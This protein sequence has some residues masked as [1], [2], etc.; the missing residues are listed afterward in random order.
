MGAL[1]GLAII[2]DDRAI[3]LTNIHA[4]KHFIQ[5]KFHLTG[6][7]V[8]GHLT[9]V[10]FPPRGNK[11][12]RHTKHPNSD[13]LKKITPALDHKRGIQHDYKIGVK[14]RRTNQARL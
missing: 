7:N 9:N 4:S 10:Y 5:T 8:Q 1:R 6:T 14:K 12:S 11:Q 2:W 3:T 13:Q